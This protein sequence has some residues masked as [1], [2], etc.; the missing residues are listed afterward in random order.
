MSLHSGLSYRSPSWTAAS[1]ISSKI[2]RTSSVFH[3]THSVTCDLL[4]GSSPLSIHGIPSSW[5]FTVPFHVILSR[6][7]VLGPTRVCMTVLVSLTIKQWPSCSSQVWRCDSSKAIT[8]QEITSRDP[9]WLEVTRKCC[10]L[11]GSDMEVAVEGR[12]LVFWMRFCFYRAVT[13]RR[14]QSYHRK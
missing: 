3:A 11:T 1:R 5:G 10:H 9:T 4:W 8:W 2:S 7:D 6:S 12:K 14:C 13:H